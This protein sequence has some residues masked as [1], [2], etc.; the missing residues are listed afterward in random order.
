MG[1][2]GWTF[3]VVAVVAMMGLSMSVDVAPVR[4]LG[5]EATQYLN[6]TNALRA[7]LGL[8]QLQDD[9]ELSALAQ[10][11][12]EHMA[13]TYTLAHPPD[14][15]NGVSAPWLLLGDNMAMGSNFDLAWNGL[16]A[17]PVHYKNL[18]EPRYTHVGTGVAFASDGTQ[19]VHQWFMELGDA[20]DL[21]ATTRT[22]AG[23]RA[24][25]RARTDPTARGRAARGAVAAGESR[26]HPADR[27]RPRR[28]CRRRTSEREPS[29][30]GLVGL[31]GALVRVARRAGR[32]VGGRRFR[33]RAA[34]PSSVRVVCPRRVGRCEGLER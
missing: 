9:P 22:R 23:A 6:A 5:P 31:L 16:V 12:A 19:W 4:A 28:A 27:L 14:I 15:R 13:A 10:A 3:L 25:G 11:W 32:G 26:G 20:V 1:R 7:N 17:S 8:S 24:G 33:P 30:R 29:D 2:R 34:W 18:S 21:R